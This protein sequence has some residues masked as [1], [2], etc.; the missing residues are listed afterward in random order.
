MRNIFSARSL[1][2]CVMKPHAELASELLDQ[3]KSHSTGDPTHR[4]QIAGVVIFLAGVDKTLSLAVQLLYLAGKIEWKWI[5]PRTPRPG[6]IACGRGLTAKLYKLKEMGLDL[7]ELQW[8]VELRNS[9][10]HNC[11]IAAGYRWGMTKRGKARLT[12]RASGPE[13]S[14]FNAPLMSLDAR[15]I[16]RWADDLTNR[17][18]TFVNHNGWQSSW[19]SIALKIAKLPVDPEPEYSLAKRRKFDQEC[20][21]TIEGLNMRCVGMGLKCVLPQEGK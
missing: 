20:Y 15:D 2:E 14:Y 3:V 9:Y 11:S 10:V 16:A 6:F 13:I 8:L 18:G 5:K 21:R 19:K 17:V 4:F 7:S 12:L 1:L